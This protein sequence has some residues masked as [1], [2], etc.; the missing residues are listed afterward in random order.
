[1]KFLRS[2]AVFCFVC[3]ALS[4]VGCD[5]GIGNGEAE[6]GTDSGPVIKPLVNGI[7]AEY[8][9][10]QIFVEYITPAAHYETIAGFRADFYAVT[11]K[12]NHIEVS[13]LSNEAYKLYSDTLT[14]IR[15][16]SAPQGNGEGGGTAG[17]VEEIAGVEP[18]DEVLAALTLA[19]PRDGDK[20]TFEKWYVDGKYTGKITIKTNAVP[21][22]GIEVSGAI[23]LS[24]VKTTANRITFFTQ[25]LIVSSINSLVVVRGPGAANFSFTESEPYFDPYARVSVVSVYGKITKGGYVVTQLEYV[26]NEFGAADNIVPVNEYEFTVSDPIILEVARIQKLYITVSRE[27]A[28][29]VINKYNLEQAIFG[30]YSEKNSVLS[31]D[32]AANTPS[33]T[34]FAS[35]GAFSELNTAIFTA[36]NV[37]YDNA[38][39]QSEVDWTVEMLNAAANKFKTAAANTGIKLGSTLNKTALMSELLQAQSTKFC[40]VKANS[41]DT[42]PVGTFYA[43]QSAFTDLDNAITDAEPVK[44]DVDEVDQ[45]NVNTQTDALLS[46]IAAFNSAKNEGAK[47]GDLNKWVLETVLKNARQA[48]TGVVI[49]TAATQ[50]D[51]GT[52]WVT[53]QNISDLNSVFEDADSTYR[54]STDQT[55]IIA[56]ANTLKAAI[57][58]FNGQKQDGQKAI[59][60]ELVNK[61]ALLTA[62]NNSTIAKTG[63]FTDTD[64][65]NTPMG[66]YWV[67]SA[68]MNTF[69]TAI[70]AAEAVYRDPN[71]TQ[72]AVN[73]QVTALN[74]AITA[75]NNAKKEGLKDT[76]PAPPPGGFDG[77][78]PEE[79]VF[80]LNN[81][82]GTDIVSD[83]RFDPPAIGSARTTLA[84][85]VPS[86]EISEEV[87]I[88]TWTVPRD[89]FYRITL[90][91]AQGG[92]VLTGTAGG[93]NY[94]TGRGGMGAKTS[95]V[96]YLYKDQILSFHLGGQGRGSI[97]EHAA[98][99]FIRSGF[100]GGG[101]G[102]VGFTS[103][104]PDGA[105]GGGATDVRLNGVRLMVA[106]GGGGAAQGASGRLDPIQGGAGGNYKSEATVKARSGD[107]VIVPGVDPAVNTPSGHTLQNWI[108]ENGRPK[109]SS[110]GGHFEGNAGAGGGYYGGYANQTTNVGSGSGGSSYVSGYNYTGNYVSKYPKAKVSDL[111]YT[112][113]DVVMTPGVEKGNG[114]IKVEYLPVN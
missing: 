35:S 36:L 90:W 80:N 26:Y 68:E 61:S 18:D 3:S 111:Y 74:A 77:I 7:V 86:F 9:A 39:P 114:N 11:F 96:I 21:A 81:I 16:N 87:G 97:L 8:D 71:A 2:L 110:D 27:A 48:K 44:N 64:G 92:N 57:A 94:D 58:V 101:K 23:D 30:A 38:A 62:L 84:Q 28:I 85:L 76:R 41:G 93:G 83:T 10:S 12:D 103:N 54:G 70:S 50:V 99:G 105:G 52:K 19:F 65:K 43:S 40:V 17:S 79:I 37:K 100:N 32:S 108:G 22:T 60:G 98:V 49:A 42:V 46:A 14:E 112:F 33:G 73:S 45:N 104:Y 59:V 29:G 113:T 6:T 51:V 13:F 72:T 56:S 78:T 109:R 24:T 5:S 88:I 15:A 34:K 102:G 106:A 95:G 20:F 4:I 89:G 55:S 66:R 91:G 1:M 75:F 107:S 53:T 47:A 69:N 25:E 63:I 82:V 31:S 67:T